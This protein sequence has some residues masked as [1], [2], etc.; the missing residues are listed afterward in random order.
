MVV[1]LSAAVLQGAPVVTQDVDLWFK[2]LSNPQFQDALRSVKGIY[3]PPFGANPPLLG[4]N[5]LELLDIVT[6]VHG[7]KSFNEEYAG[8]K[9]LK[10]GRI[11]V[12]VLPL[13]RIL[14]S[15]RSL[16]RKKDLAVIPIL[17]DVLK[18]LRSKK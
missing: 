9:K 5:G 2:D 12:R 11:T 6:T 14:K 10:L 8:S 3:V 4:G 15:K 16:K 7:L 17:E 1:G 13:A 18:T